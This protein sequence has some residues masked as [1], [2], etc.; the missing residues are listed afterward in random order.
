MRW[1]VHELDASLEGNILVMKNGDKPGVVGSVGTL[2]GAAGIN[3]SRIQMG[4]SSAPEK[5]RPCG[6]WT[7]VCPARF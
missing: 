5:P 1:G 3:I 2:L 4:R 6:L 7:G